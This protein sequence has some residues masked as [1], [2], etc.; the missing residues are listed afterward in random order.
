MSFF[1]LACQRLLPQKHRY[2]LPP[3]EVATEAVDFAV[4]LI[5]P[6]AK[7][8][9]SD[10]PWVITTTWIGHLA[11][12][13][14]AGALYTFLPRRGHPAVRGAAWGLM[15]WSGS[16][17]GWVPAAGLLTPATKHPADRNVLM[18][19]SNLLWGALTGVFVAR[20]IPDTD[21]VP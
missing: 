4:A 15:V 16:Y 18:I 10:S 5:S 13:A 20:S 7:L 3:A 12:G 1:M 8:P 19:T 9:L 11:Y 14:A 6:E 17:L 21:V 2:P